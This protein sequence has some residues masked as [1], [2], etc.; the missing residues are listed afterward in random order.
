MTLH[1]ATKRQVA[2]H[3][4]QMEHACE[5]EVRSHSITHLSRSCASDNTEDVKLDDSGVPVTAA[6]SL[7]INIGD[8][9]VTLSHTN[10]STVPW[11]VGSS[12]LSSCR[13]R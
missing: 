10:P 11:Q 8:V 4:T 6:E 13:N 9:T 2:Y 1:G 3:R 12:L 7:D 5:D